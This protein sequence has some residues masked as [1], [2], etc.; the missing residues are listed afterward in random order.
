MCIR[1]RAEI[2]AYYRYAFHGP[3]IYE[4]LTHPRVRWWTCSLFDL[5][6][7][8]RKKALRCIPRNCSKNR[9]DPAIG[10]DELCYIK[11]YYK[12]VLKVLVYQKPERFIY[13]AL[14]LCIFETPPFD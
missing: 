1:D 7:Y 10:L 13:P 5:G 11:R 6:D 12:A 2:L 14:P 9:Y 4:F 8:N 3:R